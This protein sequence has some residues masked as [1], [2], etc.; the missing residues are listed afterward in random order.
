MFDHFV[1]LALQ[2]L[3][4]QDHEIIEEEYFKGCLKT[5]Y[6]LYLFSNLSLFLESMTTY[7][8]TVRSR[9]LHNIFKVVQKR[10]FLSKMFLS[11]WR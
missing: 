7:F 1:G 6:S 10:Y 9:G 8:A 2:G 11:R 3:I 5:C 4:I